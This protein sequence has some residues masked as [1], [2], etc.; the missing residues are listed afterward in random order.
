V[1]NIIK[2]YKNFGY[3][4]GIRRLRRLKR[5]VGWLGWVDGW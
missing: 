2:S 3:I 4:L 5:E 1:G